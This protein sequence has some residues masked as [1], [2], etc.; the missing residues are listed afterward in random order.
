MMTTISLNH[1]MSKKVLG[2]KL[3]AIQTPY[4]HVL[5]EQLLI[6]LQLVSIDLDSSLEKN[7][8]VHAVYTPLNQDT[9]SFMNAVGLMVI[10]A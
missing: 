10:G 3:L 5:Q 2:S 7:L 6:T 8:N 1:L 4:M 9:I